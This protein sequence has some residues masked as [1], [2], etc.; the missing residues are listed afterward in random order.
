MLPRFSRRRTLADLWRTLACA[1]LRVFRGKNLLHERFEARVAMQ[2]I[3]HRIHFDTNDLRAGA[4]AVSALEPVNGLCL[5]AKCHVH[6]CET[7]VCHVSFCRKSLQLTKNF[8]RFVAL[9][10]FCVRLTNESEHKW[11]LV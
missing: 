3:Q 9:T 10:E 7:V 5:F 8:D 4:I 2:R 11:I 1:G 6:E